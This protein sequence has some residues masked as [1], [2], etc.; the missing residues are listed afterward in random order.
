MDAKNG[1]YVTSE[2]GK[3]SQ[4]MTGLI[5]KDIF[6]RVSLLERW[7]REGDVSSRSMQLS[8]DTSVRK[9]KQETRQGGM[10]QKIRVGILVME[11]Q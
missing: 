5:R 10:L 6:G 11:E 8:L 4:C 7:K 2:N 9:Y 3:A 1:W